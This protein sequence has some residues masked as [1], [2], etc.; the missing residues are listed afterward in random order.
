MH[1]SYR[2]RWVEPPAT[3]LLSLP[4]GKAVC[5]GR[6]YRDHALELGNPVPSEPIL[7]IKPGSALVPIEA[8]IDLPA[9]RGD[10]HIETEI[11]LLIGEPLSRAT[12]EQAANAIVGI[13]VGFD[14]TLREVQGALKA[15]GLPWEKAKAFDGSGCVSAFSAAVGYDFADIELLLL[16]NGEVQQQGNSSQLLT[17]I[18]ELTAYISEHFS[19]QPG[20]VIFT[21][22][23]AGVCALQ[24][25]DQLEVHLNETVVAHTSVL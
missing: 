8:P 23:P 6:N 14:L 19:L 10:C 3:E 2:H 17:A 16:R 11:L 12:P 4:V 20:D 22:T 21:G 18:P 5:V 15:K 7:F 25:G 24:S 1:I 9:N 13:G